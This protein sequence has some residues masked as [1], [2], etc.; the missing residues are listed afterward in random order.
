MKTFYPVIIDRDTLS[1]EPNY[2]VVFPD[3]PGCVTVGS[4]IQEALS[5]AEEA[6]EL[7]VEGMV[8]EGLDIPS[9]GQ[10][11]EADID[12]E[13]EFACFALVGVTLPERKQRVNVTLDKALLDQIAK[14]ASNRSAFLEEAARWYLKK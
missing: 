1:T 10:V 14:V 7:H 11:S 2:G 6:L 8:E 3:F 5:N 13:I 4:S 12:P 9:P